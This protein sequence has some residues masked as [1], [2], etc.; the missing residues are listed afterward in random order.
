MFNVGVG[1]LKT[2]RRHLRGGV[3]KKQCK[4]LKSKINFLNIRG[5]RSK[6]HEVN[7]HLEDNSPDILSLAE[8]FLRSDD[9]LKFYA[10]VI[11]GLANVVNR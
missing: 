3:G 7:K 8:T 1:K 2:K 10:Q 4:S 6:I 9:S 5:I 11:I